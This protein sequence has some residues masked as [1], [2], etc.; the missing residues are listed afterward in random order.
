MHFAA[1]R[2]MRIWRKD[3]YSLLLRSKILTMETITSEIKTAPHMLATTITALPSYVLG[4]ISPYPTV[5]IETMINH[6]AF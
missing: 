3:L 6:I 5:V 4:Y 2:L 1:L